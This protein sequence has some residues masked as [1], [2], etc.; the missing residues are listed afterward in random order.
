MKTDVVNT[1][2]EQKFWDAYAELWENSRYRSIF[3]APFFLQYLAKKFEHSLCVFQYYHKGCLWGA[4][5]FRNDGGIYQMLSEIK[6]DYNFFVI[7]KDCTTDEIADYFHTLFDEVKS[8]NWSLVLNYQPAWADYMDIFLQEGRES[9]LYFEV[10]KHSVCPVLESE[11]P[12]A[13][14][15][16]FNGLKNFRYYV[17]RLKKQNAVFEVFTDD[18]DLEIWTEQF[19]QC[20]V[21]RWKGTPTPSKYDD[22]EA[23]EL[24]LE[25]LRAW[26]RHNA[27]CR[28]SIRLGDERIAFNIALL[29]EN[30]LV[31][32]AQAYNP[33]YGKFS[34]GKALMYFIGEW[35]QSNGVKKIDFGKGGEAYKAGMTNG[36]LELHKIFI[37]VYSNLPF[38]LKSKLEKTARSNSGFIAVYRGKIKPRLQEAKIKIKREA[39]K[40]FKSSTSLKK[41]K[42]VTAL[43]AFKELDVV[44]DFF[45]SFNCF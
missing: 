29:Q 27:L 5:F 25:S 30:A 12:D 35:M 39:T 41:E 6:A 8:R 15:D 28:Y 23:Q 40:L 22:P 4:A 45:L 38:V 14:M 10:S 31:G 13:V 1:Y 20:H 7:H 17:N 11:T 18:E 43:V 9:K 26:T 3:Q 33:E 36:E 37:S 16:W 32:H 21:A 42:V 19:C 2:P 34:P 44:A 24:M